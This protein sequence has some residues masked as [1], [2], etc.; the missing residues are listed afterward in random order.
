MYY[1]KLGGGALDG[2][3]TTININGDQYQIG[4][5][6]SATEGGIAKLYTTV[7]GENDINT[8]GAVSQAAL[9]TKFDALQSE[10]AITATKD[11][12][13]VNN[14]I[15][16]ANGS[17]Y[18]LKQG[19]TPVITFQIAKDIFIRDGAIVY[20]EY[21]AQ[22]DVFT[23][24][25]A[26]GTYS[27]AFIK[28]ILDEDS[29]NTVTT[30]TLYIPAASLVKG[31]TASNAIG[32]KIN[33]NIDSNNGISASLNSGSIEKTDLDPYLQSEISNKMNKIG[34]AIGGT[35]A[36]LDSGGGIIDSGKMASDF[37][38]AGSYKTTQT[39]KTDPNAVGNSL[40]FID[41]ISQNTN[42]EITA[43]KKIIY[44]AGASQAGIMSAADY[45]KL[46]AIEAQVSGDVLTLTTN[47]D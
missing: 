9:K 38:R 7:G 3:L 40:T 36:A 46:A 11:G 15:V 19:N 44:Y 5:D 12:N 1:E 37:Q 43:T 16:S 10:V 35:F 25:E 6:A 32:S 29:D 45:N 8:D 17:T 27:N 28:L 20:G 4:K 33:I 41:S 14:P 30:K 13:V 2:V 39:A 26:D 42:G 47:A 22:T 23:E 21:D 34:S 18:V 31:Y 24:G